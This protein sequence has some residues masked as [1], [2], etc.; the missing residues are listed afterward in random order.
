MGISE[1]RLTNAIPE[2]FKPQLPSVE[3]IERELEKQDDIKNKSDENEE[4]K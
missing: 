3:E 1:Y 4:N 2:N